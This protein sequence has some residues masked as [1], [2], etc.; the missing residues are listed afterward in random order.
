MKT[1]LGTLLALGLLSTT[2]SAQYCPPGQGYKSSYG[3]RSFHKPTAHVGKIKEGEE[4]PVEVVPAPA[5][6]PLPVEPVPQK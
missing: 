2:A 6:A 5:P 3:Q 1:I 4:R